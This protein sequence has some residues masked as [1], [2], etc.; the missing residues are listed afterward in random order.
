MTPYQWLYPKV[1]IGQTLG[2]D[3]QR[4]T[5]LTEYNTISLTTD[6]NT[7][8]FIYGA[9]YYL[10]FGE[11]G[12]HSIGEAFNL[13]G[14][15]LLEFSADS[16]KVGSYQFRPTSMTVACPVL[17][18]LSIYGCSTLR[19]VLDLSS[20]VKLTQV[21]CRGT[22]L[23]SVVFPR[24][25]TLTDIYIGDVVSLNITGVPNLANF[26]T[27][28]T[29]N[30]TSLTTDS[31]MVI[32]YYIERPDIS[33]IQEIHLNNVNLDLTSQ[34]TTV[35]DNMFTLLTRPN[36]TASGRVYLNKKLTLA[37][38]Q[39]LTQKYGNIDNVSN[40]LY[41]EYIIETQD[42]LVI[43]GDSEIT[44]T[45]SKIYSV[46][47]NGNDIRSYQWSVQ[48]GSYQMI[49]DYTVRVV[50]DADNT[51]DIIVTCTV[52][53]LRNTDVVAIK[54]IDVIAYIP[55]REID[56]GAD[57]NYYR[58]G[59]YTIPVSYLPSRI[60]VDI[61]PEDIV[62]SMTG[63]GTNVV[64]NSADLQQV[65]LTTTEPAQD[66]HGTLKL[67]ATDIDGNFA[68]DTINISVWKTVA[69]GNV[70]G[71]GVNEN[72]VNYGNLAPG[73][74][75]FLSSNII[76]S[77]A[78]TFTLSMTVPAGYSIGS[79][80][81]SNNKVIVSGN[82]ENTITFT[83][84][85]VA[86]QTTNITIPL[87]NDVTGNIQNYVM[88]GV[89]MKRNIYIGT[90]TADTINW[91]VG[92]GTI[93]INYSVA[94]A[95]YNVA[96][97]HVVC[98]ADSTLSNY[99]T[100][101][102]QG[103]GYVTYSVTNT[104]IDNYVAGTIDVNV[105]DVNGHSHHGTANVTLWNV[106]GIN[107]TFAGENTKTVT[108]A[109]NGSSSASALGEFQF[110]G[111][112]FTINP[113]THDGYTMTACTVT[114][115]GSQ[116]SVS[117][118]SGIANVT[119]SAANTGVMSAVVTM[120]NNSTNELYTYTVSSLSYRNHVYVNSVSTNDYNWYDGTTNELTLNWSYSPN[121]NN[122]TTTTVVTLSSNL[123]QYMT[124]KSSTPSSTPLVDQNILTGT[125]T[126]TITNP[127]TSRVVGTYTVSVTTNGQTYTSTGNITL[128][129]DLNIYAR[130]TGEV[131]TE[132]T[133]LHTADNNLSSKPYVEYLAGSPFVFRFGGFDANYWSV[134]S[135]V[136]ASGTGISALSPVSGGTNYKDYNMTF[137]STGS[138]S[139]NVSLYNAQSGEY[140]VYRLN[141]FRVRQNIYINN[142]FP[143]E[144][145]YTFDKTGQL[146]VNFS[147]GPSNYNVQ[148]VQFTASISG[149]AAS[150]ASVASVTNGRCVVNVHTAADN[151]EKSGTLTINVTDEKGNLKSATCS[152]KLTNNITKVLFNGHD[153]VIDKAMVPGLTY[154]IPIS[155]LPEDT[156]QTSWSASSI[157]GLDSRLTA[158]IVN[159]RTLRIQINS[160][161]TDELIEDEAALIVDNSAVTSAPFNISAHNISNGTIEI[162]GIPDSDRYV[163]PVFRTIEWWDGTR[164]HNDI[165]NVTFDSVTK[166]GVT[167]PGGNAT[168]SDSED[169]EIFRQDIGYAA[170]SKTDNG[171]GISFGVTRY[172][173][174]VPGPNYEQDEN[175]EYLQVDMGFCIGTGAKGSDSANHE[176]WSAEKYNATIHL[177]SPMDVKWYQIGSEHNTV[178]RWIDQSDFLTPV[179]KYS[180]STAQNKYGL[181]QTLTFRNCVF[182]QP[183]WCYLAVPKINF[184]NCIINCSNPVKFKFRNEN[185]GDT[186]D[187]NYNVS[188]DYTNCSITVSD[189]TDTQMRCPL[190]FNYQYDDQTGEYD[191]TVEVPNMEGCEV[192]VAYGDVD[193]TSDAY[194]TLNQ[195]T[196]LSTLP[197][198]NAVKYAPGTTAHGLEYLRK[199]WGSNASYI[200]R[201]VLQETPFWIQIGE[202]VGTG[203]TIIRNTMTK[204]PANIRYNINSDDF[205][206]S[207]VLTTLAAST[208]NTGD[209]VYFWGDLNTVAESSVASYSCP[210]KFNFTVMNE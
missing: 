103:N 41:V 186:N 52:T 196:T 171:T 200:E 44:Q 24:T 121:N 148:P 79:V 142:I 21:D 1:G 188:I 204:Y 29:S 28:G 107:I 152:I 48:N 197:A 153:G 100:Y 39:A 104:N 81:S 169:I 120:K 139:I 163:E 137:G 20:S 38:Q 209:K 125:A 75:D 84:T 149:A 185:I 111:A 136:I 16:R 47:Y 57:V 56:L 161:V 141:D 102:S 9:D 91:R 40:S 155:V 6:G 118:S 115:E 144:S 42:T 18:K 166:D 11:F 50:A 80:S 68:E 114:A 34:S 112:R 190:F 207:T 150:Y 189:Y 26:V 202:I 194:S 14:A 122:A 140:L 51:D 181:V 151:T 87:V 175:D 78:T 183:I 64:I 5:A 201:N 49:N 198:G 156:T 54:T 128:W 37:E 180:E 4:V 158:S 146:I 210:I 22:G 83:C 133:G 35:S 8:S 69:I 176:D 178:T 154:D 164:N 105:V 106:L 15:R 184:V 165:M 130:F 61:L 43:T 108:V 145:S 195:Q 85:D 160:G 168:F 76:Q 65:V 63:V 157:S 74:N 109:E 59:Q 124:L 131:V 88:Q 30:L 123:T 93:R 90:V 208:L 23:S 77:A 98:T 135:A 96:I 143:A 66:I 113:G 97:D 17:R 117:I 33:G 94:P 12:G 95:N 3:N 72:T 55:I 60:T 73:N 89:K 147:Y 192:N 170:W 173:T 53:R 206:Q 126:Y 70:T 203:G 162:S 7:D 31:P 82:T 159:N 119:L 71:T 129:G 205:S 191:Y 36:S 132:Y 62:A 193:I 110:T 177:Q 116:Q 19:G 182:D 134:N 127:A 167:R 58:P 10:N 179:G 92:E 187:T 138:S 45:K 172:Y 27:S 67:R 46:A 2:T 101:T 32:E 174:W 25:E 86:A 13:S 199:Q 99:L